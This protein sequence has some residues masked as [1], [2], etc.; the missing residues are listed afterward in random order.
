MA[1]ASELLVLLNDTPPSNVSFE[2]KVA[3]AEALSFVDTGA[4]GE[5]GAAVGAFGEEDAAV[6]AFVVFACTAVAIP[7]TCFS[8]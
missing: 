2:S 4:F 5:D 1:K 3:K 8:E 6:G 7:D